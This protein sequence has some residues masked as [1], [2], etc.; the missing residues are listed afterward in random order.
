VTRRIQ[1]PY[2][3]VGKLVTSVNGAHTVKLNNGKTMVGL[4]EERVHWMLTPAELAKPADQAAAFKADMA[5][6]KAERAELEKSVADGFKR[7]NIV[8][9]KRGENYT[10]A[11]TRNTRE[12]WPAV[13]GDLDRQGWRAV[14]A[15]RVQDHR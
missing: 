4:P 2:Q 7:D 11:L 1:T 6:R 14:R 13:P 5:K 3:L 15:S 9:A 10:I 12:G 8:T